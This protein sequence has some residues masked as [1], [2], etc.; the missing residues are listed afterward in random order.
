MRETTGSG[1]PAS[2][3]LAGSL[4]ADL[5][6]A[7]GAQIRSCSSLIL[8]EEPTEQVTSMHPASPALAYD[9]QTDR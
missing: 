3:R 4:L 1:A 6:P 8:M 5:F 7:W 2:P 9:T